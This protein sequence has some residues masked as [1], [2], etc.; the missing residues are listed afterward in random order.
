MLPLI[1]IGVLSIAAATAYLP[2][3]DR[4]ARYLGLMFMAI[5]SAL[6][7]YIA[8]PGFSQVGIIGPLSLWYL[9]GIAALNLVLIALISFSATL[10]AY[11]YLAREQAEQIISTADIRRYFSLAPLLS[12]AMYVAVLSNH[13]GLL[14]LALEAATLL[15][16]LLI[17]F[18]RKRSALEAAW[19]SIL[20]CSLGL[21]LCLIGIFLTA[22]A[23][24]QSGVGSSFLLSTVR[25]I[26]AAQG[27]NVQ[28]MHWA[29]VFVFMGIGT[30]IGLVPMHTWLPDAHSKTPAPISALLSG[31]LLNVALVS[32]LR[33]RQVADLTFMD[34]GVWTGR[35]FLVFGCLSIVVPALSLMLQKNYKRLLAYSSIEHMGLM[36]LAIGLGPAGLV[37]MLMHMPGHALLKSGLFFG[38]GE[39]VTAYKTTDTSLI[40]DVWVKLPRT[41]LLFLLTLLMLSAIP[42]SGVFVSQMLVIG[43]GLREHVLITLVVSLALVVASVAMIRNVYGLLFTSPGRFSNTVAEPWNI[44]HLVMCLHLLLAVALG[45]FY[46][47]PA[48]LAFMLGIAQSF[49]PGLL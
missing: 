43:L 41:G 11:R 37:P 36:T 38:A 1:L 5:S 49:N 17:A 47:T 31:V 15:M 16:I 46:I 48:G 34:N 30:M 23:A 26:A 6:A 35:L 33:F 8:W 18:Y 7:I 28:I 40:K 2:I 45:V 44:T 39:I 19:K 24:G 25:D 29:F 14:W 12:A 13:L 20:L 32:L 9:D 22:Y 21:S 3:S 42:P 10:A 4:R 27:M